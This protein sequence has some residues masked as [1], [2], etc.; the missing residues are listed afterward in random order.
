MQHENLDVSSLETHLQQVFFNRHL[1]QVNI[2][3]Q[4]TYYHCNMPPIYVCATNII[5][6]WQHI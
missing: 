3:L 5:G 1:Q 4:H 2:H 6:A